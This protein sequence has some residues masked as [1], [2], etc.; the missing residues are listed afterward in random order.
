MKDT[1]FNITPEMAKRYIVTDEELEK[2][3]NDTIN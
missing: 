2:N 1:T 3:V